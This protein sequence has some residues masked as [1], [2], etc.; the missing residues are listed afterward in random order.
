MFRGAFAGAKGC[1]FSKAV[2][3]SPLEVSPVPPSSCM[4]R[5]PKEMQ[6]P[7]AEPV[8]S[9]SA[10]LL[11]SIT[12]SPSTSPTCKLELC[13]LPAADTD[14]CASRCDCYWTGESMCACKDIGPIPACQAFYARPDD[15][16]LRRLAQPNNGFSSTD[17]I[18]LL[19]DSLTW[20]AV[21]KIV[22]CLR[23]FR[24]PAILGVPVP[25]CVVSPALVA[26]TSLTARYLRF[27]HMAQCVVHALECLACRTRVTPASSPAS[28]CKQCSHCLRSTRAA[29]PVLLTHAVVTKTLYIF[30]WIQ[31]LGTLWY[32]ACHIVWLQSIL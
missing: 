21:R 32:F 10:S 18:T 2:S 1:C 22:L 24:L 3:C 28:H 27:H 16:A 31:N 9:P 17:R 8:A 13:T 23:R 19:G 6:R 7:H 11:L 30:Q 20:Y 29:A 25:Q 5:S 12:A 15:A 26:G 14:V 4:L